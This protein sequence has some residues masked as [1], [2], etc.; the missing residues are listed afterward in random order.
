MVEEKLKRKTHPSK[1]G[2]FSFTRKAAE[3]AISRAAIKFDVDKQSLTYFRTLHSMA[4][5]QLGLPRGSL[6]KNFQYKKFGQKIGVSLNNI[7]LEDENGIIFPDREAEFLTHINTSRAKNI[8][9]KRQWQKNA[10]DLRWK[11][12]KWLDNEYRK[13]KKNNTLHDYTDMLVKFVECGI[14]PKLDFLFI[15]EAQDLSYLQWRAVE[16]LAL[17]AKETYIAGD[18]DQAIFRW[19]GADVEHFINMK[20]KSQVLTQSYRVPKLIHSYSMRLLQRIKK[21]RIK[22]YLSRDYAGDLQFHRSPMINIEKN[23][24]LVLAT[25]NYILNK[26]E[27]D[28][29]KD[30]IFFKRKGRFS[31]SKSTVSA[32]LNWESLRRGNKCVKK[33]IK[34]IYFLMT[35][36]I[37]YKQKHKNLDSMPDMKKFSLEDLIKNYGLLTRETWKKSLDRISLKNKIYINLALRKKE[38]INSPRVKI[39][40]V[41]GAKGSECDNVIMFTDLSREAEKQYYLNSDDLTRVMYVGATRAKRALHII[42][43]QTT[44]GFLV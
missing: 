3:E 42:T 40:T 44:R 36:N 2:Y 19:A 4:C 1:I 16:K 9:L 24:W 25:T 31:V 32:I 8:D 29:I 15:D 17:N 20:G 6:M 35:E 21:R 38:D 12:L 34:K 5:Y 26:I 41:H 14:S 28:L 37:G 33:E 43:P 23:Q 13:Y 39:S 30:G 27:E 22:T 7:N 10:K 18:D 11:K